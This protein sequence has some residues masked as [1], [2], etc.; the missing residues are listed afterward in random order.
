L[1]QPQERTA[2][3]PKT[4]TPARHADPKPRGGD[5]F[6]LA[7]FLPYRLSVTT[8]RISRTFARRYAEAFDLTIPEWRVLAVVGNFAPMSSSDIC[9]KT[10]MDKVKVSRAVSSL[11]DRGLLDRATDPRDQRM[12]CLG[13]SRRGE[14][15]YDGVVPLALALEDQLTSALS[16]NERVTL[17]RILDKLNACVDGL[18]EAEL[19][20]PD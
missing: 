17:N 5:A 1:F 16:G 13:L 14:R 4:S 7:D 12:H 9:I 8:N 10:A 20:D 6:A 18:G 11:V 15:V 3:L 19:G 2:A